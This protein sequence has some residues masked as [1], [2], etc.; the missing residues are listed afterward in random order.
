LITAII[1]RNESRF[2]TL[3]IDMKPFRLRK[4]LPILQVVVF[5]AATASAWAA[6]PCDGVNRS[7]TSQRKAALA[8]EIAKHLQ[9]K[10]IGVLQSFQLASWSIY[11]VTSQVNDNAYVFYAHDPLK[12]RY[13][14]LWG[15]M[16]TSDEEKAIKAW[17]LK[18]APGIPLRLATCFAWH[19]TKEGE[20]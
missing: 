5:V 4:H 9:D 16:A 17:T 18:N 10:S 13:V 19:V 15:G 11:Y 6:S 14:T 7:L 20:R 1:L 2:A 8:P 12:S 3:S